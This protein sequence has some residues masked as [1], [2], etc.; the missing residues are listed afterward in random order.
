MGQLGI[1]G[2]DD[3]VELDVDV[4]L[5]LERGLDVDLGNGAMTEESPAAGQGLRF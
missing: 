4:E 2:S 1:A 5:V 3:D